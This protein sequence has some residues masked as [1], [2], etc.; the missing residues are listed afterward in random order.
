MAQPGQNTSNRAKI[1]YMYSCMANV[2]C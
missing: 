2:S 1:Q